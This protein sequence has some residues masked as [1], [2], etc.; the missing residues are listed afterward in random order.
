MVGADNKIT[1][2]DCGSVE[3][4]S[5]EMLTF[6]TTDKNEYDVVRKNWGFYATPSLNGRLQEFSLRGVLTRNIITNLYF[7][8]LVESGKEELFEE[9]R[10]Q[11]KMEVVTWLDNSDVL[12]AVTKLV[13][14]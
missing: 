1:I 6:L 11:E 12:D 7:I 10:I 13:K 5:D 2:S 3:L 8:F 9:Y 14:K 4:E